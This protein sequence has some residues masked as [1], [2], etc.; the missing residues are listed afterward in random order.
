MKAPQPQNNAAKLPSTGNIKDPP[1]KL[2]CEAVASEL[3]DLKQQVAAIPVTDSND[4]VISREIVTNV[5]GSVDKQTITIE[6]SRLIAQWGK[7]T[8]LTQPTSAG[9]FEVGGSSGASGG[10]GETVTNNY[11][12]QVMAGIFGT[13]GG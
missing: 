4:P 1:V 6:K 10:G 3:D 13:P 11:I 9:T 7:S 2:F 8:Y 5:L 12:T